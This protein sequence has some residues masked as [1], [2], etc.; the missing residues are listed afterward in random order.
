[1][2]QMSR[3]EC[4]QVL[5]GEQMLIYAVFR[6]SFRRAELLQI[7]QNSVTKGV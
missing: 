7:S 1:M 5:V 2:A 3:E 6:D 4:G